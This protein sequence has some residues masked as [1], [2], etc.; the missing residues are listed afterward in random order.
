MTLQN[1]LQWACRYLEHGCAQGSADSTA[2]VDAEAL[3]EYVTGKSSASL[4]ADA[5]QQ[6]SVRQT[7]DFKSAVQ[8]R[9]QGEPIAYLLGKKE[10]WSLP[11]TITPDVL[12]PRTESELL[13]EL[14]L[15]HASHHN[16]ATLLE[17]GTGSGAIA[18][19]LASEISHCQIVATDICAHAIEVA[20]HNQ[21][22][23]GLAHIEFCVG[24]WFEAVRQQRFEVIV[25]NPPY[26]AADDRHL[27]QGDLR[28]EP[29]L[30][31]VSPAEG[32]ADLCRIISNARD[33]LTS[34]GSLLLEH[35]YNQ[36]A[37][38]RELFKRNGFGSITTHRDL[39][40]LERVTQGQAGGA[41][42]VKA[43]GI[44]H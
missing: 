24:Y 12:I 32:L 9:A 2:N 27:Q 10:F 14:V 18:L 25:S 5:T 17:L 11:L 3:L 40:G 15:A 8:R 19:A 23:L 29:N 34:G 43:S 39:S 28:F 36:A 6:L 16:L 41:E 35:G 20:K 30:A 38:V 31:L 42:Q 7:A 22:K 37:A 44:H 26:V 1:A 4:I 33:Y 21:R 13:V